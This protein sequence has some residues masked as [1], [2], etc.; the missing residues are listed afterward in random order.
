MANLKDLPVYGSAASIVDQPRSV[1]GHLQFSGPIA[2][3][4]SDPDAGRV[5]GVPSDAFP[6]GGPTPP[7]GTV[8]PTAHAWLL[9]AG[10]TGS[11]GGGAAPEGWPVYETPA[12]AA[13]AVDGLGDGA[14]RRRGGRD[15]GKGSVS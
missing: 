5:M 8:G 13:K 12:A 11:L 4:L 1:S 14:D 9:A 6:Y 2:A 10:L 15:G 7:Q 3:A